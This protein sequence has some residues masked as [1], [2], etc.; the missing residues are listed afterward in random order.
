[1]TIYIGLDPGAV[2]GAWAA[3][4]HNNAFIGCGDIP[5]KDGQVLTR[6]LWWNLILMLDKR[7]CHITIEKVH[8]MPGQGVSSSFKFGMAY[9]AICAVAERMLYPYELVTPQAWKK[10]HGLIG[11]GKSASLDV[12]RMAWPTADLRLKKHHGRA[13]ALLIAAYSRMNDE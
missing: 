5:H 2:S 11:K 1:M 6:Q 7:D 12:A 4:D 3:I 13:D 10:H 8:S 9:G